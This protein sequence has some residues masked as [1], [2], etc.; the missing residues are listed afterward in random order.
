MVRSADWVATEFANQSSP[1]TFYTMEGQATPS[2]AP[3]IESL[4]PAAATIGA[5]VTIQGAG[6]Q[7]TQGTSTVAFN[8]AAATPTSWNDASILVPV[9][10]AATTGNVTVTV[11]GGASNGVAFTVLPTPS[12]TNLNPTSG[13]VGT[14]VTI[15]GSQ[16]WLDAGHQHRNFRWNDGD[17]IELERNYDHSAGTDWRDD[18]QCNRD[19][20]WWRE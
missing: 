6:F 19:G 5:P 2:S 3:A 17:A 16:F 15:T 4:S 14:L 13:T 12:I 20:G 8:G 7:P 9:P 11:A 1:S 18:G 10:A